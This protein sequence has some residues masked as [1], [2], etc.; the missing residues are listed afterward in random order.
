MTRQDAAAYRSG[1]AA[2]RN[3]KGQ[4]A[5][6]YNPGLHAHHCWLMGFI[7]AKLASEG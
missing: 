3:G 2:Y 1:T 4:D 5:N 6:P 7:N